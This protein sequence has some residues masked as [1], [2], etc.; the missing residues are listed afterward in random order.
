ANLGALTRSQPASWAPFTGI[1]G[2][3]QAQGIGSSFHTGG[4]NFVMADGS[5]HF[6]DDRIAFE[7]FAWL[8]S[9]ADSNV[10]PTF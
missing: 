1:N 6:I 9:M 4:A 5:A 10:V 3:F 8:T 2:Y 7:S